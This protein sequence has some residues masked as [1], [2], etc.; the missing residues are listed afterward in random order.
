L[1]TVY[2]LDV[3]SGEMAG[4]TAD[5]DDVELTEFSDER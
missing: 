2:E 4:A 1:L 3:N 5:E